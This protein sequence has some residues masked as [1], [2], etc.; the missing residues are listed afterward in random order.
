MTK[1]FFLNNEDTFRE[2]LDTYELSPVL[3]NLI[4]DSTNNKK[5]KFGT[6]YDAYKYIGNKIDFFENRFKKIGQCSLDQE[7]EDSVSTLH[8]FLGVY[9]EISFRSD[10]D[11]RKTKIEEYSK[12]FLSDVFLESEI[13]II[14]NIAIAS[15]ICD[16]QYFDLLSNLS[17]KDKKLSKRRINFLSCRFINNLEDIL[18]RGDLKFISFF[19]P[20]IKFYN[21]SFDNKPLKYFKDNFDLY[22][23]LSR[24][25]LQ[26]FDNGLYQTLLKYDQI[27]LAIPKIKQGGKTFSDEKN[28]LILDAYDKYYGIPKDAAKATGINQRTIVRHWKKKGFKFYRHPANFKGNP[29]IYYNR[30]KSK[31]KGLK[32]MELKDLDCQLYYALLKSK[33]L[34]KLIPSKYN[35]NKISESDSKE[36]LELYPIYFGNLKEASRKSKFTYSSI[37]RY[38]KK[39]NLNPCRTKKDFLK[40]IELSNK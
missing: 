23:G 2:I 21:R 34:D 30:N 33:D 25:G 31:F 13:E 9:D 14:S 27:S 22:R 24:R 35:Y 5:E 37:L 39:N 26:E 12:T 19:P 1:E 3:Y 6:Y 11:F 40:E 36:I 18:S 10:L 17:T 8:N 29:M 7:L 38:W 32:R 20:K 4:L 16:E 15:K 28:K